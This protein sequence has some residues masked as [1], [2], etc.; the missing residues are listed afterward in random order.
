M[1]V[2]FCK[3]IK[4]NST[5]AYM[6]TGNETEFVLNATYQKGNIVKIESLN[7]VYI[8][9]NQTLKSPTIDDVNWR[10]LDYLPY[11]EVKAYAVGVYVRY[12]NNIYVSLIDN[13]LTNPTGA[14]TNWEFVKK[15][16]AHDCLDLYFTSST[17][18]YLEN[19]VMEIEVKNC[20]DFSLFGL[21]G[22]AVLIEEF[23]YKNEL[24]AIKNHSLLDTSSIWDFASYCQF[25]ACSSMSE[26]HGKLSGGGTQKIRMTITAREKNSLLMAEVA[27]MAFGKEVFLGVTT[28]GVSE[29]KLQ[30][31]PPTSDKWGNFAH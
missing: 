23:N 19:L 13:N 12:L 22:K 17:K 6:A 15:T 2:T 16:N 20:S 4:L 14:N 24:I 7:S 3:T 25:D 30:L 10:L 28:F 27:T 26:L 31:N 8:A 29:K 11:I 1:L 9:I 18:K 21:T 5:N